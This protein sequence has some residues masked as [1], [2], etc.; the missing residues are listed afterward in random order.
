M[1]AVAGTSLM[2]DD[3]IR[4]ARLV[5]LA[6]RFA[7]WLLP[8]H[9]KSWAKAMFNEIACIPSRRIALRW[10]LGC[11]LLA[12]RERT[13]YEL[14]RTFVHHRVLKTLLGLGAAS[15]VLVAGL[16]AVQKPYQRERISITLH[17][18]FE[19]RQASLGK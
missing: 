12:V 13:S 8:P 2:S 15:V 7:T 19:A 11:T 14:G 17:R 3:G 6:I 5:A 10:V 1:A 18:I 9:R 4:S 16:Y